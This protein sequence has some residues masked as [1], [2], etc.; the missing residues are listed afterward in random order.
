VFMLGFLPG[1]AYMGPLDS[2]L[3]LPRR[4]TPRTRVPAGSVAIAG[5]QTGIYPV[6]APGGWHVIGRT[7]LRPYDV[8]RAEPCLFNAGDAVRFVTM[9]RDAFSR[10]LETVGR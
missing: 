4:A 3:V 9:N 7:P 6:E 5:A 10:A 1:F 8:S 2:R